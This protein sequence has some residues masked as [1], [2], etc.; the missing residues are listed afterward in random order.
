MSWW[1]NAS[2]FLLSIL[3]LQTAILIN[4][5]YYAVF[6]VVHDI[7]SRESETLFLFNSYDE[8][9]DGFIDL[10]EFEAVKQR[11]TESETFLEFVRLKYFKKILT[12]YFSV[13]FVCLWGATATLQLY[14]RI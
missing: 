6:P 3:V 9:A 4:V 13:L 8:N 12:S 10:F 5:Y 11:I 1:R 7:F 2:L 14:S